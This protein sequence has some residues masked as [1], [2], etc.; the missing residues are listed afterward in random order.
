MTALLL[1]WATATLGLWLASQML[2]GV[3]VAS[4]GDALRAG[5]L[6]ALLQWSLTLAITVFIGVV[7]LGLGFVFWFISR[8]IASALVI[9]LVS[10]LSSRIEVRGF[11][12]ALIT[13]FIVSA[14]G[15]ALR[16]LM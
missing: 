7:T 9:L 14:T 11:I 4:V 2:D 13:T 10:A 16:W 5:A 15:M 1:A 8:W 6:L 12:P 3:R